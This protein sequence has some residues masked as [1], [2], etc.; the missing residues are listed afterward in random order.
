MLTAYYTTTTNGKPP[1][2]PSSETPETPRDIY[3]LSYLRPLQ[4]R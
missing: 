2:E 4:L 3:K 1:P